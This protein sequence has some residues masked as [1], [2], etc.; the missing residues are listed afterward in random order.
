VDVIAGGMNAGQR[1]Q[2]GV[3]SFVKE[4]LKVETISIAIAT[5]IVLAGIGSS[6]LFQFH[7]SR[8]FG[9]RRRATVAPSN[10]NAIFVCFD[11]DSRVFGRGN[12]DRSRTWKVDTIAS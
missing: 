2:Y 6:C 7:L 8:H 11:H 4:S 1:R 3:A 10:D 12:C 5:A 9:C